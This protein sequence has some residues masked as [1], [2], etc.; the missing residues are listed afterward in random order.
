MYLQAL[1]VEVTLQQLGTN[2]FTQT[3]RVITIQPSVLPHLKRIPAAWPIPLLEA[4]RFNQTPLP[5]LT[6]RLVTMH[7]GIILLEGIIQR[8]DPAHLN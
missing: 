8:L 4:I 3:R 2:R 6:L 1:Q 7:F 5:I